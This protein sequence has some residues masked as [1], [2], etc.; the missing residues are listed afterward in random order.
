VITPVTVPIANPANRELVTVVANLVVE[1]AAHRSG[2]HEIYETLCRMAGVA[3][4]SIRVSLT[5]EYERHLA[6]TQLNIVN[7]RA[8]AG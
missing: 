4:R 2:V 7:L 5:E 6:Q 1:A 8:A 3:P